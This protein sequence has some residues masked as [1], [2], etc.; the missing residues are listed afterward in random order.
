M[1]NLQAR[2]VLITGAARRI[3]ATVARYLHEQGFNIAIHYRNSST[4]AL[5]LV[6]ELN[7]QRSV[8]AIAI[9]ADLCDI[10]GLEDLL[11]AVLNE[12]GQLDVLINNA[13]SFFP[14]KLG[15]V[16]EEQW[17]NLHCSNLKAPFFLAQTVADALAET[18]GCIVNMIDIH[19]FR[20]LKSYPV[21]SAAK[22]GLLML[23]QS[24]AR[25]LG[26]N[27][28]VNGVAPGAI[29]WPED[30]MTDTAQQAML[31]KTALKR[32]GSAEDIAYAIEF[33]I[34]RANYITG[35]VIPVD[36]GRLLNH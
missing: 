8:S 10:D 2:T 9:Q 15:T 14:T 36:G 1:V 29:M 7:T 5:A 27:V 11:K 33:L 24:L 3:G 23:T 19:G 28:R 34:N 16:T 4:D 13:S 20:P 12:F 17:D 26:P 32:Q 30:D 25:E 21:Y 18:Q 22:A 31:S 35:H 6:A